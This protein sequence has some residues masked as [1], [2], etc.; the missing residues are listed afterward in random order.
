MNIFSFANEVIK[1]LSNLTSHL[2]DIVNKDVGGVSKTI[3]HPFSP[4]Q[5]YSKRGSHIQLKS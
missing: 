1:G 2:A 4:T 3:V 5:L